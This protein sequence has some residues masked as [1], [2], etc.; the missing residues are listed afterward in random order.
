MFLKKHLNAFTI[1]IFL[2]VMTTATLVSGV[3]DYQVINLI[4][5]LFIHILL[6]YL[7]IYHFKTTLYFVYIIT[8]II[9]DIFLLNEFGTHM[10]T[11]MILILILSKLKKFIPSLSAQKIFTLITI[12]LM[13][14]LIFRNVSFLCAVQL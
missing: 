6:I 13:F 8:S 2:L 12:M 7:G 14:A 10:I 5:Y 4:A 11:F 9:L 3:T 1:Y